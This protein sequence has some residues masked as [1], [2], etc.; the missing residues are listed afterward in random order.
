MIIPANLNLK[1]RMYKIDLFVSYH[2]LSTDQTAA[3]F[4]TIAASLG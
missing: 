1:I 2:Y 4:E 3:L